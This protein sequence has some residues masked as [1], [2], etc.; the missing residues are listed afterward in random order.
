MVDRPQVRPLS[1]GLLPQQGAVLLVCC[2]LVRNIGKHKM[3]R[4]LFIYTMLLNI[5]MSFN[6]K[7]LKRD[8][9]RY[10]W[11]LLSLAFVVRGAWIP[12]GSRGSRVLLCNVLP[13]RGVG[14]GICGPCRQPRQDVRAV[15]VWLRH[16]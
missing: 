1:F 9:H 16:P 15:R 7:V 8:S 6:L 13:V 3:H 5:V 12:E 11:Q 4:Y 2:V 14:G 10:I